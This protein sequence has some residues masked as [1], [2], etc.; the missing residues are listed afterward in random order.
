MN[1]HYRLTPHLVVVLE[2][3]V[4]IGNVHEVQRWMCA[5]ARTGEHR[6]VVADVR[7]PL[8]TSTALHML[9]AFQ[10]VVNDEGRSLSLLVRHPLALKVLRLTDLHAAFHLVPALPEPLGAAKVRGWG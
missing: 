1:H 6:S 10:G 4:D 9:F 2:D 5:V 3:V 8:L 7:S